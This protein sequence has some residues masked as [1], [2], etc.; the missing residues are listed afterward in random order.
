MALSLELEKN[1]LQE[2]VQR[3][4]QRF[5]TKISLNLQYISTSCLYFSNLYIEFPK[6]LQY[7]QTYL[8]ILMIEQQ[9]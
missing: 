3:L 9:C 2:L 1:N 7:F 6:Y 5:S 4:V 8:K